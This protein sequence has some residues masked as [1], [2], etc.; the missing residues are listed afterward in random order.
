MRGDDRR[1]GAV[2]GYVSPEALVPKDHPLRRMV[3]TVLT[4]LSPEFDA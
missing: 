4:T 2:F 3:D 1:E